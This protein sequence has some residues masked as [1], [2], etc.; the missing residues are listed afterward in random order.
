MREGKGN[1][2]QNADQFSQIAHVAQIAHVSQ[3]DDQNTSEISNKLTASQLIR[4]RAKRHEF[5][6]AYEPSHPYLEQARQV[7]QQEAD[8]ISALIDRLGTDFINS[9]EILA[10]CAG[11]VILTGMGKSGHIANKIAATL[12]STGTPSFFVHPGEMRHGDFG[13][14][15]EG[16]VVLALSATGETR[17]VI[18]A[19]EPIKRM[20]LP[21]IS[22]TGNRKSTL[23]QF[24]DAV[25]DV[26]VTREACSLNLAPTS[27]TTATLAMGDALAIVLMTKKALRIEDFARRH[28]G[29]SL[30]AQLL[31]VKDVMRCG[32]AIPQVS[33]DESYEKILLEITDKKLGF[34][35]V[36]SADGKLAGL[37]T[38]GDLRRA[39]VEHGISV[40]EKTAAQIMT[41]SP[42]SV[43]ANALAKE[44]L[45]L[46]ETH[47]ISDLLILD[48]HEKV[49]GLIDLKDLLRAGLI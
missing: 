20:G 34:T 9:I 10:Q 36:C 22:L 32:A 38:D 40:F 21:I 33:L 3:I 44:A 15:A 26:A 18:L 24:S 47:S 23:A 25:I 46:M 48:D 41:L 8:A 5:D 17:E 4:S 28:P 45:K 31:T 30:G 35:T 13:M 43:S 19:L 1:S 27:S 14:L 11:K 16:D 12:A 42:K 2:G 37:I 29:G 39:V 6:P 49:T 7:L